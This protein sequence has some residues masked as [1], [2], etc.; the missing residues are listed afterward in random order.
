MDT[1][2]L[3][4]LHEGLMRERQRLASARTDSERE[5]R[6]V[7][8]KQRERELTREMEFLGIGAAREMREISDDDLLHELMS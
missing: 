2:H 4:A 6:S 3:V 1:S 8:V 5:M 7:W